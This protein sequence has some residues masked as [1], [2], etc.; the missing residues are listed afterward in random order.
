VNIQSVG[1]NDSYVQ[2]VRLVQEARARTQGVTP[3]GTQA[4]GQVR[5]VRRSPAQMYR[6]APIAA[7]TNVQ[8]ASVEP[9][10]KTRVLG[11]FFDT[12]A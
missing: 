4:M 6:S 8:S 9:K 10:A 7:A 11:S 2:F 12:Y 5:S 3:G 1:G